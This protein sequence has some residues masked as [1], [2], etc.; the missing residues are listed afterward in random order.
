MLIVWCK[1][2]PRA[3]VRKMWARPYS[4]WNF[5]ASWWN[6]CDLPKVALANNAKIY[7][8]RSPREAIFPRCQP[9][10]VMLVCRNVFHVVSALHSIV[11]LIVARYYIYTAAK[12][13]ESYSNTAFK[14]VLL[15]SKIFTASPG[16]G[17]GRGVG[18]ALPYMGYIVM[19]REIG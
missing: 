4:F 14:V 15:K 6:S 13:S 18:V 2:D 8:C 7:W 19:C 1:T 12:E 17:G 11:C 9:V 5:L 10:P 16:A 3:S